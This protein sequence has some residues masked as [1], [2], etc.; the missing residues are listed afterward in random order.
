MNL[1]R[2]SLSVTG[3]R[4]GATFG[5]LLLLFVVALLVCWSSFARIA[6]AERDMDTFEHARR[7]ADHAA[8]AMR[9]QYIHQAHTVIHFDGSHLGHYSGVAQAA[10]AAV[11]ELRA[12]LPTGD[13]APLI[14]RLDSI[15][16]A[17]DAIFT[18]ETV[19][20]VLR[21]D[22]VAA[23]ALHEQAA[24][25]V[26]EF[27]EVVDELHARNEAR[28]DA[29]R[30]VQQAAWTRARWAS[31]VCFGGAVSIA[32]VLGVLMT[33]AISR[34]FHTLLAGAQRLGSGDL[35]ARVELSTGDEFSVLARALNDM[36][37]DLERNQ[38]ELV[39][40][41]RLAS[42]GQVA[43]TVAHELNNPLGVI[44]GYVKVLRRRDERDPE[45]LRIIED[46]AT[47]ASD[48]VKTLLEL[49]RPQP[50]RLGDVEL[51][52]VLMQAAN[53]LQRVEVFKDI[54]WRPRPR[55]ASSVVRGDEARLRQ[56]INNLLTNAAEAASPGGCVEF[57]IERDEGHIRLVVEDS[58]PG[59]AEADYTRVTE[60]FFTTKA[61]GFGLGLAIVQALV[62]AHNGRIQLG[63]SQLGGARVTIELPTPDRPGGA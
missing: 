5:S 17:S 19:P 35:A 39:R 63:R 32:I 46:E 47:L 14:E 49:T 24:D 20:A 23:Q 51:E 10:R 44:L 45:A 50:L 53:R 18:R 37:A 25:S 22:H 7:S 56:V 12:N 61:G 57:G 28:A 33:R 36:A 54:D 16:S 30:S 31:Y 13:D 43:A 2:G 42:I 58:G 41:Q 48:I 29:A 6:E 38:R 40:T 9:E 27:S 11:A 4:L 8:I 52:T 26:E 3:R 21:G 1:V 15:Q 62:E 55:G 34:R 59:I 60:P